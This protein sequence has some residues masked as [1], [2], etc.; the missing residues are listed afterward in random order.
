MLYLQLTLLD[1]NLTLAVVD[2]HEC[3]NGGI[4]GVC[5]GW[6]SG[7]GS[8]WLH[9]DGRGIRWREERTRQVIM[10]FPAYYVNYVFMF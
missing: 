5:K 4:A 9:K 6:S 3:N 1:K 8:D 7:G 10:H 2:D